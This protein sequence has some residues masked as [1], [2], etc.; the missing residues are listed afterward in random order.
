M[1]ART[2]SIRPMLG[3]VALLA[4]GLIPGWPDR[5]NRTLRDDG[6]NSADYD[7]IE[8]GY[9]ERLIEP[10]RP[11]ERQA[12]APFDAG[13]LAQT[14]GDVREYV[15]KP[16]LSATHK[17]ARWTTN[18]QGMRDRPYAAIKPPGT[19]RIGLVG[20]SIATGWG[21]D[22]G[23]GFE[24]RLERSWDERVRLGQ[25]EANPPPQPSP[26]GGEGAR[27]PSPSGEEEVIKPSPLVGE[28]WVGGRPGLDL[29]SAHPTP[30]VEI[31]NFSVP[32]HAPGQRWEHFSRVAWQTR[33]DLVIF[34]GTPA[35]LGWDE[36]RLRALI[37]RGIG[38]DAP[39][40]RDVLMSANI[41]L[42]TLDLKSRL[43]PLREAILAGVYRRAVADCRER[44]VPAVWLLLPRVGKP[45]DPADRAKLVG[46][47]R[48]AGFD[49][50]V[51]VSDAFDGLPASMLAIGAD[52]FHPN[53]RGHVELAHRIDAA[54]GGF[55][56]GMASPS[57]PL[58][59]RERPLAPRPAGVDP[60]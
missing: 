28:G 50:I 52:D 40:Y 5:L 20:D 38:L 8:R 46:L 37:P 9:Y 12:H 42:S 33:P 44:G 47:A 51:D 43:R 25:V 27:E 54:L 7:R 39:V 29:D 6:P 34:E 30:H 41:S 57:R 16:D 22:D 19:L 36:R 53:A 24:P 21:V 49:R 31:L 11:G 17:G 3:T 60:R 2:T 48:S 10:A 15:L 26:T 58:G 14:V 45:V 32:G 13:V 55:V 59:V 35:D 56:S 23:L 4:W 1:D 18:S